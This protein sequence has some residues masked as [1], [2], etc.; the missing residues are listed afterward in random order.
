MTLQYDPKFMEAAGPILEQASQMPKVPLHDI[1]GLRALCEAMTGPLAKTPDHIEKLVYKVPAPDG[2]EIL[3]YHFRVRQ[4]HREK[5]ERAVFHIHGGGYIALSAEQYS[6]LPIGI[7]CRTGVQVITVD[8]RLAP[9]NPYPTALNDCW[10]ALQWVH[11]NA[12]ELFIDSARMAVMGESSGGGLAAALAIKAR[13]EAVSPPLAK[14]IL[15]YPMLDDRTKTDHTGG[16]LLWGVDHNTSGWTAYLGSEVGSDR[17][18]AYAAAARVDSVSGLPPLYIDCGQLDLFL[19]EN[20]EYARRFMEANIT[21]ELHIYHG[22]P[23]GFEQMGSS[24]EPVLQAIVNRDK[25]ILG[26]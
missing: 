8:Y 7:V 19:H 11:D 14:Q 22:L 5:S 9:E 12:Q 26:L 2:H 6:G 16:L 15:V 21:T 25:A 23:H 13:D 18:G 4:E 20:L 17:V 3:L 10:V 24:T 1:S